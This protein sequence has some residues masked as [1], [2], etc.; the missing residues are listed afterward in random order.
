MMHIIG[1]GM[2]L[3][4]VYALHIESLLQ[5]SLCKKKKTGDAHFCSYFMVQ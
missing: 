1:K 5:M 2:Y 3:Y 4:A